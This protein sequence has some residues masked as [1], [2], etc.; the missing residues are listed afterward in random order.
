MADEQTKRDAGE[1][2]K[3]VA[4]VFLVVVALVLILVNRDEVEVD[5]LVFDLTS[6]LWV[7]LVGT[8]IVGIVIGF[9]VAKL[10]NRR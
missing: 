10:R 9:L 5:L 3:L 6:P 4:I 8:L 2:G 1:I 7:T